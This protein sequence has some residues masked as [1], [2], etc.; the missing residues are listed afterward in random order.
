MTVLQHPQY[1][2]EYAKKSME[3]SENSQ[4]RREAK[5]PS[6]KFGIP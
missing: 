5:T 4:R 1:G 2:L 3:P 6:D